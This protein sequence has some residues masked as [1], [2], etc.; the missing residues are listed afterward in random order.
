M[1]A[2]EYLLICVFQGLGVYFH[3]L[4]KLK[5]LDEK[6][7]EK[8]YDEIKAIFYDEDRIT[9]KMSAGILVLHLA[10]HLIVDLYAPHLRGIDY[11]MLWTLAAA[12]ILGW[13]GQRIIYKAFGKAEQIINKQIDSK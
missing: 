8:S 3:I 1:I 5:A 2:I 6:F 11:Y 12:I 13:G 9:L 10:I 7:P 4:A